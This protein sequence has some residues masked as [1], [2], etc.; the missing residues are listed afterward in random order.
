LGC[1][2]NR[3]Y[4]WVNI[5]LN[6]QSEADVHMDLRGGLPMKAQSASLI[7]SEHV[8]EHLC[9]EDGKRLMND[10]H[11]ALQD[12]GTMRTAMPDLGNI[13]KAYLGDWRKQDW[14]E[15]PEYSGID[16]ASHMLNV[17]LRSW[18]HR[19]IYD[20]ED[21]RLRLEAAGFK[22]VRSCPWGESGVP[23]LRNLEQRRD[24]LLIVEAVR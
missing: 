2:P 3:F 7:Y 8:L 14:L 15:S 12:G 16:T 10:C 24:S 17:G 1:G 19:Y 4:G 9:L 11:S 23:E 22:E 5:D 18:G 20:F 21:L 6:R 13:V